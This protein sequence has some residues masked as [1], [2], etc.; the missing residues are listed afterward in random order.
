MNDPFEFDSFN[1]TDVREEVIAPLIRSLGY[2]SGTTNTVIREQLL[3]YP[4]LSLGRKDSRK[5]PI[6]RG[7]ADYILEAM[8]RVRWVIEAKAPSVSF[9]NDVIEQ[10]WTYANHP[11]VR[12]VYFV[13]CNGWY[14]NIYLTNCGPNCEAILSVPHDQFGLKFSTIEN[15]LSPSALIRDYGTRP[16]DLNPPIAQG[17]RSIAQITNGLIRYKSSNLDLP[18]LNQLQVRIKK[19]AIERAEDGTLKALLAITSPFQS[20]EEL[21]ERLGISTLEMTSMDTSLSSNPSFSTVFK[22][23]KDVVIPAGEKLLDF[24]SW[25]LIKLDSNVELRI[26]SVARGFFEVGIF[27]GDFT[28]KITHLN[29]EINVELSGIFLL[30]LA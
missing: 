11:E 21:N 27:Q 1:E 29:R 26:E 14:F 2:R 10:A 28:T 8:G 18:M 9:D 30:N 12:A 19:G 4:Q 13:L 22:Y 15:I 5:D 3:R 6:L 23:S 16:I 25:D 24:R 17:L 7:K 20:V